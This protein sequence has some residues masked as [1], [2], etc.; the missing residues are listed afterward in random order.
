MTGY[1]VTE[2]QVIL[3]SSWREGLLHI[4]AEDYSILEPEN[5]NRIELYRY[6][7]KVFFFYKNSLEELHIF[8][9]E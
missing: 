9:T 1:T 6:F 5:H 7:S 4:K 3:Q 2:E 8:F